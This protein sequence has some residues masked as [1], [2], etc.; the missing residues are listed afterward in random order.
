[1]V[2]YCLT[3]V[4]D[5]AADAEKAAETLAAAGLTRTAAE[6]ADF[7]LIALSE[8]GQI[9]APEVRRA[10]EYFDGEIRWH[11]KPCGEI[12]FLA[13]DDAALSQL[14]LRLKKYGYY[15]W[16]EAEDAAAYCRERVLASERE[17]EKKKEAVPAVKQI[18]YS[19]PEETVKQIE[20][21]V[22]APSVPSFDGKQTRQGDRKEQG[23][24]EDHVFDNLTDNVPQKETLRAGRNGCLVAFFVLLLCIVAI[25]AI[26]SIAQ[27]S[28][29]AAVLLSE[30]TP[31]F[32]AH[33]AHA[34]FANALQSLC[35]Y[36]IL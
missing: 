15:L 27:T 4:P 9:D 22:R 29:G 26:A 6:Q 33:T 24:R 14:P 18:R 2:R 32:D 13:Q 16:S 17:E 11:R 12:L 5:I 8:P 35:G 1:M 21:S 31:Q 20:F 30:K 10:W 25:V 3:Y 23:C 7:L 36:G 34:F 28:L 19:P